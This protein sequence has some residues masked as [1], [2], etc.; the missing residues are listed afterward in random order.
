MP[1][2]APEPTSGEARILECLRALT[3]GTLEIEVQ[4]GKPVRLIE[5]R[6]EK[7]ATE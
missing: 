1:E 4:R 3:W 5:H 2:P 6:S 7:L